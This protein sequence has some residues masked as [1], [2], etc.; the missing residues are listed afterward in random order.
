MTRRSLAGL[1]VAVPFLAVNAAGG[2]AAAVSAEPMHAGAHAALTLLT[3]WWVRRLVPRRPARSAAPA[4]PAAPAA[5]GER[6]AQLERAVDV[7]AVEVERVGE[8]QRYLT[9]VLDGGAP[10]PAAGD[11]REAAPA[12]GA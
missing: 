6:L 5:L 8:G 3:A 4:A 7:V 9:R 10:R 12:R 2:V 11:A 1:A